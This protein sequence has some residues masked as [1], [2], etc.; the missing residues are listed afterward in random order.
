M[1][2]MF[3]EE[4]DRLRVELHDAQLLIRNADLEQARLSDSLAQW[5]HRAEQSE[6]KVKASEEEIQAQRQRIQQ[7]AAQTAQMD[8]LQA[9]VS[10]VRSEAKDFR[11]EAERL[12][13]MLEKR[14]L[15]LDDTRDE[16]SA[17]RADNV[18]LNTELG[19]TRVLLAALRDA[20][21]AEKIVEEEI[22]KL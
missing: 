5:R 8:Q 14:R 18:N 12:T 16:L 7:L 17:V 6:Q 11:E 2:V 1:S 10:A 9:E 3:S 13:G 22:A 4:L 21:R 20:I 15:E 19:P